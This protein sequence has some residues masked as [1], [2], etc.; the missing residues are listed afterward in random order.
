MKAIWI[1]LSIG[2]M[3]EM[4]GGLTS[5]GDEVVEFLEKPIFT[6]R[7]EITSFD[8][9]INFITDEAAM[10]LHSMLNISIQRINNLIQEQ[11]TKKSDSS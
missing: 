9:D 1:D 7:S 11:L 3:V 8:S 5:D 6:E 4:E 2:E 10:A